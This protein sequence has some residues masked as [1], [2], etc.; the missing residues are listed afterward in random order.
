MVTV[1]LGNSGESMPVAEGSRS[2]R[3]RRRCVVAAGIFTM[4]VSPLIGTVPA[5]AASIVE[6]D[7]LREVPEPSLYYGAASPAARR[8]VIGPDTTTVLL[9]HGLT[10]GRGAPV[11]CGS[12]QGVIAPSEWNAEGWDPAAPHPVAVTGPIVPGSI[13]N[14]HCHQDDSNEVDF[15]L[16]AEAD[17]PEVAAVT[18][19]PETLVR[20]DIILNHTREGYD[21][22]TVAP[23]DIVRVTGPA[24]TWGTPAE[25]AVPTIT[26][27]CGRTYTASAHD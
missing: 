25:G 20:R 11:W 27:T 10:P 26:V 2:S 1:T 24:G 14:Y 23:G 12:T 19:S 13:Y 8:I 5:Q 3:T 16:V 17:A 4:L 22:R 6:F 9:T 18:A 15:T 7:A 21:S